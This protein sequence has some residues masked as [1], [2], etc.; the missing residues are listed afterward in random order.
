MLS[1]ATV[2]Y[3]VS[4][5]SYVYMYLWK[6]SKQGCDVMQAEVD[7]ECILQHTPCNTCAGS[8]VARPPAHTE[9][10]MRI[11]TGHPRGNMRVGEQKLT[12]TLE[13]P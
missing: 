13:C 3:L 9:Q 12:I 4:F 2:P 7:I 8:V 1:V 11:I 5:L 6:R 10:W